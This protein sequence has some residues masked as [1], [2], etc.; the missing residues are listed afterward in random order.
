MEPAEDG[1]MVATVRGSYSY[2]GPDGRTIRVDY[3][4]DEGGFRASGDH[5]PQSLQDTIYNFKY[6]IP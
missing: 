3:I 5:L 6:I 4:A 1:R 2:P